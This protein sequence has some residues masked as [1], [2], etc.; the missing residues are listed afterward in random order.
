LRG[1]LD[2]SRR[3]ALDR[4]ER[5]PLSERLVLWIEE[6]REQGAGEEDLALRSGL[7]AEAVR[8]ALAQPLAEGR[9]HALR[10]SPDRYLAEPALARLASRASAELHRLIAAGTGAVG[11]PRGTLLQRILPRADPR[12]AE[13]I[14]AA[15]AARGVLAIAGDEARSPGR[16]DLAGPDRQLS[17]RIEDLFRQR[18]LDPPSPA[19][20]AEEVRHRPKVVEGL[21]GYLVKKGA[22]VRL[23]GGWIIARETV[24]AVVE[25]LRASGKT[26]FDV[27]EFK[28][29]FGLTRRLA[30]PLLEHLD[31]AKVTRRVGD[32]R[33]VLRSDRSS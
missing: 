3:E 29:M 8:A 1:R 19:Q 31:A 28:E 2:D 15:L 14:E 26:T 12:W 7:P 32:R 6:A 22:L 25:G 5:G 11:V 30:I 16:T 10:R 24:G 13:A 18:G 4:L 23:P 21:I 27:G 9:V 17:E 33:E 20:A